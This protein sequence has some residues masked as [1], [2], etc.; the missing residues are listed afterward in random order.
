[1]QTDAVVLL[2]ETQSRELEAFLA[3]RIYEFNS[4]ATGYF[5]GELLGA[6]I[7]NEA[8]EVIAG[9]SGHTWGGC[10]EISHL[11]VSAHHRGQ[12]LGRAILRAAEAQAVR[13][14]CS[15]MVLTTH[16][17]QAPGFYERLGYE[18]KYAIEG[19]PQGH[20]NIVFVKLLQGENGA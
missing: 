3:D 1:M 9:L 19:R 12:G 17:F 10:C 6:S 14:A 15:Q 8:G 4:E 13:R 7:R 5:D 11:W 18:R 2:N 20:S 16:S